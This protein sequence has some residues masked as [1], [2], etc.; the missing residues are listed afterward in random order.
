MNKQIF[1]AAEPLSTRK[2]YFTRAGLRCRFIRWEGVNTVVQ[3]LIDPM[4]DGP[5]T[6]GGFLYKSD[7]NQ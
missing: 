3:M 2:I 7:P 5:Q 4:K 6:H 1:T